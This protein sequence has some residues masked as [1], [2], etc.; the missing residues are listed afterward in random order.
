[1]PPYQGH[2]G[3]SMNMPGRGDDVFA[4]GPSVPTKR[5]PNYEAFEFKTAEPMALESIPADEMS[6]NTCGN[7]LDT[8]A[9]LNGYGA[10]AATAA[11]SNGYGAD[12]AAAV[13][14]SVCKQGGRSWP[15]HGNGDDAFPVDPALA[16]TRAAMA[17]NTNIFG[18]PA[19]ED[20]ITKQQKST[21]GTG[22][23][24][25]NPF[26]RPCLFKFRLCRQHFSTHRRR[27]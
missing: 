1:M 12:S 3:M 18:S 19:P 9:I 11:V 26:G 13:P 4:P 24:S 14:N 17:A 27:T 21:S 2:G 6:C 25:V 15:I 20:D 5:R 7:D 10:H 16:A 23:R 8:A 22:S